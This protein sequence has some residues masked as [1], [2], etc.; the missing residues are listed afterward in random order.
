MVK[1]I[2]KS[3]MLWHDSMP[4]PALKKD[5]WVCGR[6]TRSRLDRRPCAGRKVRTTWREWQGLEMCCF[7]RQWLCWTFYRCSRSVGAF[8][9][10]S[11]PSTQACNSNQRWNYT[12]RQLRLNFSTYTSVDVNI[13]QTPSEWFVRF[14]FWF[15][16][17]PIKPEDE[18][19]P[20]ANASYGDWETGRWPPPLPTGGLSKQNKIKQAKTF[21]EQTKK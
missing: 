3:R 1:Y 11:V 14:Q 7:G 6:P 5:R 19:V 12:K 13:P 20:S 2:V 9:L 8:E 16:A 17:P 18:P 15:P 10:S 21:E 4:L